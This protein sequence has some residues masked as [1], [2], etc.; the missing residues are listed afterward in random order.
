M[1]KEMNPSRCLWWIGDR[2]I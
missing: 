1:T 2:R